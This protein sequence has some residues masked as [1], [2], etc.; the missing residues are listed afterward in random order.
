MNVQVICYTLLDNI[1]VF[2][3]VQCHCLWWRTYCNCAKLWVQRSDIGIQP[4]SWAVFSKV[5]TIILDYRKG[6]VNL[7]LTLRRITRL[8]REQG[9]LA[10]PG[11]IKT[12]LYFHPT[13]TYCV[14]STTVNWAGDATCFNKMPQWS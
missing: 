2:H 3:I 13:W 7:F 4:L 6:L 8:W 5:P 10:K 11:F 1:L 14:E 9:A 12:Y